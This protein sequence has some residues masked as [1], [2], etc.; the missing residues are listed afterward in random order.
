MEDNS[1]GGNI[2]STNCDRFNEIKKLSK[3]SKMT[4]ELYEKNEIT[5]RDMW[6]I[7]SFEKQVSCRWFSTV[8][9]KISRKTSL[10]NETVLQQATRA[11]L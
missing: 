2:G 11:P 10:I 1:L 8:R 3:K 7:S 5:L 9:S 6:K 4:K